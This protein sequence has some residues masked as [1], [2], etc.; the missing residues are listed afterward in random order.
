MRFGGVPIQGEAVALVNDGL[1]VDKN[2][3]LE[4]DV[5]AL[6][7]KSEVIELCQEEVEE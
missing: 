7:A 3:V 4:V 6:K 1:G 2:A 5:A